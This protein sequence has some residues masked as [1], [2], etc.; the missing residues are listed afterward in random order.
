MSSPS[1]FDITVSDE[2]A[3]VRRTREVMSPFNWFSRLWAVAAIAHIVGNPRIGQAFGDP[4]LLGWVTFATGVIAVALVVRPENRQLLRALCIGVLGTV[5][6]EAPFVGNHWL[7]AG[8]VSLAILIGLSS[9]DSWNWFATTGRGMHLAF[10]AFAA[11]AK[12]NSAFFDTSVSCGVHY[13]NQ[14]LASWG[15]PELEAGSVL[16]TLAVWAVAA[17]ELSIPFM[18]V[19]R[20]WR[21]VGVLVGLSFHVLVSFDLS[22]HFYDF[23][24][25]LIPLFLLW[26]RPAICES[27]GRPLTRNTEL[28]TVGLLGFLVLTSVM[29]AGRITLAILTHGVFV[30]WIPAAIAL[31]VFIAQSVEMP[32]EPDLRPATAGSWLLIAIVVLNGLAPYTE[33]KT[34]T[35]WNMYSN[36]HT[37]AG[38]SN[39]F[40]VRA[41][42]PLTSAQNDP[43]TI[44]ETTDPGLAAYVGSGYVLPERTFLDYLADHPQAEVTVEKGGRTLDVTGADGSALNPFLDRFALLRAIDTERPVRCQTTWLPAR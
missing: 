38:E 3:E 34:A 12:L 30:A 32:A 21:N 4:T 27:L 9:G 40:I 7:L 20:R 13:T 35:S 28:M 14:S 39:H 25:V 37:V 29:P 16:A 24:A 15:L 36:L 44:R 23:T 2:V 31:V 6:L 1:D 26:V 10:Y 11:F 33:L 18:L 22:Q 41:T 43:V 5:W 17:I 8:L 42:A 19:S